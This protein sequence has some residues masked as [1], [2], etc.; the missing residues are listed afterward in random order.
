MT[1]LPSSILRLKDFRLLLFTRIF[2]TMA[3]QAQAVIVGWQIYSITKDPFLL[4]VT[5][6]VEAVPAIACALFA[7]HVVDIS[8]PH[9]VYRWCVGVLAANTLMLMVLAGGYLPLG[10]THTLFWLYLGVF[11]SGVARSFTMPAS[12]SL[13]PQIVPRK[14]IAAASAW[15]SGGFQVAAISGPA[16]AGL[17]YAGY[18]PHGAWILP[19]TLMA[20]AFAMIYCIGTSN[21]PIRENVREPALKSIV[22]GW[23]FIFKKPVLLSVMTLDMFAVL[24]GGAVAMLPVFADQVLHVGAEGLGALRAAPALGAMAMALLLA[25]RPMK[26]LSGAALLWVVAGFGVCMIGFGLSVWFWVSMVFL[27]LG[28][29]FDCVSMVIRSTLMQLL[30]P[31]AMRGRVSSVNSMF[32]ISSNEIGAFE[33]GTMARLVG[34][35]PS[36][37]LGG[38]AT[39]L[40]VV[41]TALLSP[42]LRNTVV[43]TQDEPPKDDAA[44]P[45]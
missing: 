6:L 18:G 7:G 36:V 25:L 32:V 21:H 27:A 45:A 17:V 40:V 44:R 10:L 30:T 5:G 38:C 33:S 12:F 28:G 22:A 37:V 4:G 3:L 20:M 1:T 43:N 26:K 13:L 29:A 34:L 2:V 9:I 11:I 23:A 24:F 14:D 8:R 19:A 42:Q 39:L 35:V 31:D 15:L 41:M 16:V